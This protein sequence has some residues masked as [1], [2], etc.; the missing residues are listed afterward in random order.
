MCELKTATIQELIDELLERDDGLRAIDSSVLA[1]ELIDRN[2]DLKPFG[3]ETLVE[4][5]KARND[6]SS[7]S[8]SYGYRD[9]GL[10]VESGEVIHGTGKVTILA[11]EGICD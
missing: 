5:L 3:T 6:V 4:A 8:G 9:Y 2:D 7:I 1:D 10:Y 11:I